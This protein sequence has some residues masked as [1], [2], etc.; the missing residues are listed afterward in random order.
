[1]PFRLLLAATVLAA[2]AAPARD[3]ELLRQARANAVDFERT[4]ASMRRLLH[5]WLKHADSRT[6]LLP[7]RVAGQPAGLK[8]GDARVY[9]PHNSGADLYPYLILTARL[10]D[11]ALYHGRMLEMLRNEIRFTNARAGVPGNLDLDTGKLGPPSL[12]GAGEYAKD[13]LLAVT[14]Y[15]GRTPWY[16]RMVDMTADAMEQAPVPS[17]FGRLPASDAELNGDFMQTLVRLATM[18][19]DPRFLAWGRRI[20]D[21]YI[22]EVLPGNHGVPSGKWDFTAHT[23]DGRLR[24]RDHGNETVVGL[25]L[26]FAL[27]NAL[28]TPRAARYR[29]VIA[30]MLDRILASANPDGMLYNEVDAATLKPVDSGLSDNWGYIYG[31][32]FTFYQCTGEDQ[33]RQAVLKVLRNLPKYR[34]Y[35]WE[36]RPNNPQRPLGSFDGYADSIESALYLV[37]R[38]PVPEALAWIESEMKVMAA[39]QK[40]DGHLEY[41]YGEGNYNRTSLIYALMKSQGV[42]PAVW[43]AGVGAGAVRDGPRLLLSLRAAAPRVY[44][45][46][47]ARHRR[48]INLD[49]N[50]VRLNEIPEWFTAAENSLYRLR[51]AGRPERILL[52]SELIAGVT[53]APGDWIVEPAGDARDASPTMARE[54]LPMRTFEDLNQAARGFQESRILLTAIELDIFN[55]VGDGASAPAI[56][57]RIGANP[58]ATAMLLDALVS[59]EALDKSGD[60]YRATVESAR[61]RAAR[62]GMMH[63]VNLWDS[64]ST[65]TAAV[66]SGAAVRRP[67]VEAAESDWTGAFIDAMHANAASQARHMVQAVGAAGA[68]RLLDVGGGSGAYAIAFAQAEPALQADVL[69]LPQ[70]T[71]IADRHIR[72]A[73]LADRVRTKHGDLARD[74]LGQGYDLILLSAI[75]HMLSEAENF[76]LLARCARAL[77]PGGRVVIRDFILEPGRTAPRGAAIFALNMLVGTRRGN[78]YTEAEYRDWLRNAGFRQVQRLSPTGDLIVATR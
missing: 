10:T 20:A 67:G 47:H 65:L 45:F 49:K 1:M 55:A 37:N 14:E 7:D 41:W 40:P 29:P 68:K 17:R 11:P 16:Y 73:G 8:P 30:R 57:S 33:Y 13:G 69:D 24:L 46:D 53:L 4:V 44:V 9:T 42:R 50:Y 27:E 12:F 70:V 51:S 59:L 31:A 19:S 52:G 78:T 34:R 38:E 32:V 48:T 28:G 36:G 25:T 18:T 75:C 54:A 62:P 23:G 3:A 5:A 2:P 72:A 64:W 71:P 6:L 61:F 43:A 76:D 58:R 74:D 22:E 21:A 66:R 39:M 77:L 35:I 56:A 60:T 15:L 63:T 26:Q